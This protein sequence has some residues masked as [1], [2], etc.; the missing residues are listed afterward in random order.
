MRALAV[1]AANE[2]V[3]D[4]SQLNALQNT[5]NE[6]MTSINRIADNTQFGNRNLLNGELAQNTWD[7]TTLNSQNL[8]SIDY[9]EDLTQNYRQMQ[10]GINYNTQITVDPP[11][12][13][14]DRSTLS[15]TFAGAPAAT[16]AVQGLTQNGTVLSAANGNSVE[17]TGPDGSVTVNIDAG[18][19][20]E[21]LADRINGTTGLSGLRANYN[22]TTGV[23]TIESTSFGASTITAV[24]SGDMS[25]GG[26]VGLFDDDTTDPAVNGTISLGTNQTVDV[27]YTDRIGVQTVTLT[28]D[29]TINGGRGFTNS[30]F[31][32]T[33]KDRSDGSFGSIIEVPDIAYTARRV[34]DDRAMIGTKEGQSALLEIGD[35][36]GL[37]LGQDNGTIR[38]PQPR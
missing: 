27:T 38:L 26:D 36:H 14:L 12:A 18:M 3:Q 37:V 21:K 11:S 20:I 24:A 30:A 6:S 22:D 34:N 1:T 35:I 4:S 13:N 28:Q 5:F 29:P 23:F 15:V 19:T 31:T 2:G 10:N 7:R 25:G 17:L 32:L 9:Y 16:T 8:R 33:L